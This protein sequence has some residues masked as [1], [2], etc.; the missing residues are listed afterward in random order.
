M[1]KNGNKKNDWGGWDQ[2]KMEA[3]FDK[4][5]NE[6]HVN[7]LEYLLVSLRMGMLCIHVKLEYLR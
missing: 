5:F 4:L 3:L 1:I 2:R 6:S 7:D